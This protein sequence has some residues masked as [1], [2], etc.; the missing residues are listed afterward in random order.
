MCSDIGRDTAG[1]MAALINQSSHSNSRLGL[2]CA[3]YA[4]GIESLG[5]CRSQGVRCVRIAYGE[6]DGVSPAS[7]APVARRA[8]EA[9]LST[10]AGRRLDD[11]ATALANLVHDQIV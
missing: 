4:R 6:G 7:I 11:D 1:T 3:E 5:G 8:D 10:S 9:L 2:P